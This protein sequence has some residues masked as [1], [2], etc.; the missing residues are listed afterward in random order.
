MF[1]SRPSRK[2]ILIIRPGALGDVIVTLPAFGAIRSHF[3]DAHI[4][5]MGNTSFLEIV[6]GRFYADTISRFDQGD[7]AA[8]FLKDAEMP[9]SVMRRFGNRDVIVPIVLG[10]EQD[11]MRNLKITGAQCIMHCEPFPPDNE[12][13]H[14]AD[15]FLRSLDLWGI[16]CTDR[17]PKLFLCDGDMLLGDSFIK[18][19]I[20]NPKNALIALHPGSGSRQKCWPVEYFAEL[21]LWLRNGMDA[22]ILV[23]AGPA[24]IEI[25]DR[26]RVKVGS[27]CSV[28]QELPLPTLA[29]MIKRCNLFIGNDSGITHLAA[30]VG[31]RTIA[32]FGPT[33]PGIWRPLGEQVSVLYKK[34]DCSPCSTDERRRCGSQIC[35]KNISVENVIHELRCVVTP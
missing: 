32:I 13:I 2:H 12:Q 8:L 11:F 21:I 9:D 35:L 15:H 25:V 28:A 1:N 29:A 5:I 16:P 10:K 20:K 31:T 19:N 30:A 7:I 6:N 23:I 4:E 34:S 33:D 27:D 22:N 17:I 3:P 18:D 14:I 24:D 26:L